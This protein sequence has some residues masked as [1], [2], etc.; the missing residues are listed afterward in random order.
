MGRVLASKR[1]SQHSSPRRPAP[2]TAH[3]T[4]LRLPSVQ[5]S[6]RLVTGCSPMPSPWTHPSSQ[7]EVL[8]QPA[9]AEPIEQ[10]VGDRFCA[11]SLRRGDLRAKRSEEAVS[12]L[13]WDISGHAG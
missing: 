9:M 1:T 6:T 12:R 3:L 8:P 13:R 4:L 5:D 2:S 7:V 11:V 10:R